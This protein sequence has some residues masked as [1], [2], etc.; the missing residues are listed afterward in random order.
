MIATTV[1]TLATPTTLLDGTLPVY[2][3]HPDGFVGT[4]TADGQQVRVAALVCDRASVIVA[5]SLVGFDTSVGATLS[6][7]W[8]GTAVPFTPAPAWQDAWREA[9][10]A[11]SLK[12]GGSSYKQSVA[13]LEGTREVHALALVR[14]AHLTEG[15]L[16]PPDLPTPPK[17]ASQAQAH[18]P[19]DQDA[20]EEDDD[21][22]EATQEQPGASLPAPGGSQ[23]PVWVPRYILGNW[24]E[25]TPARRV[26]QGHLAAL[27][28]PLL[29]RHDTHP[30]WPAMWA[31]ALWARGLAQELITPLSAALGLRAWRLSGTLPAWGTLV[32]TG[33]REGWLPWRD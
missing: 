20:E 25:R 32:G 8:R 3:Y 10:G 7:L 19:D 26:F 33:A 6:T 23:Q 31:D 30:E 16:H 18:H 5:L 9:G 24:D 4:L 13:R 11:D 14:D 17:P 27:R 28:V 15:I 2:P 21:E 22:D 1:T 29:Y 12:R